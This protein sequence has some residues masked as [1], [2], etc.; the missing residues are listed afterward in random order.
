MRIKI[1]NAGIFTRKQT[2]RQVTPCVFLGMAIAGVEKFDLYSPEGKKIGTVTENTLFLLPKDFTIDFSF[3]EKRENYVI[4]CQLENLH[5]NP[6]TQCNELFSGN[7]CLTLPLTITPEP[8]AADAMR[9]NFREIARLTASGLP[10]DA[11][12]GELLAL[13]ILAEFVKHSSSSLSEKLH[14]AVSGLKQ[15][16]DDDLN[17]SMPLNELMADLPFTPVHL[18]RL[19]QQTFHTTPAEYRSRKRFAKIQ[20]LMIEAELNLKEIA[21]AVGMNNVTHLNSFVKKQCGLTPAQLR[22]NIQM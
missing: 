2:F 7:L 12:A 20:Q 22:K 5:W 9:Q 18:R 15:A 14:P 16:I 4:V 10:A 21:E 6:H 17:F 8:A 1:T 19:F 11:Q 3:N 13:A